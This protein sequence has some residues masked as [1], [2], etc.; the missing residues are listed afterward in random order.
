M[1]RNA[2]PQAT[3]LRRPFY[4]VLVTITM[5]ALS[6]CLIATDFVNLAYARGRGGGGRGGG[7]SGASRSGPARSGSVN[8]NN[9]QSRSNKSRD[10]QP[11][12]SGRARTVPGWRNR[13]NPVRANRGPRQARAGPS[14]RGA[15]ASRASAGGRG[16]R[17]ASTRRPARA[18]SRRTHRRHCHR[19][20][21]LSPGTLGISPVLASG[22]LV[23]WLLVGASIRH[24]GC[25][26][27]LHTAHVRGLRLDV[28]LQRR[29]LVHPRGSR[30]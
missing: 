3:G 2:K 7:R 6:L 4:R 25:V 17:T 12:Q 26:G 24:V 14:G 1:I 19:R 20:S 15:G 23:S 18:G 10:K 28:L 9:T 29:C 22:G 11:S 27:N 30:G 21:R 5:I 8:R 13:L 16:A